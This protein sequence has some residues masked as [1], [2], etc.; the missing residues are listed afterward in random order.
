MDGLA[1]GNT[2][3][4]ADFGSD[5]AAE[6]NHFPLDNPTP[7]KY[8]NGAIRLPQK[9]TGVERVRGTKL[10]GSEV[11]WGVQSVFQGER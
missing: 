8:L 4:S 6:V 2:R 9:G 11:W 1:S 5:F 3:V 10:Q 7:F